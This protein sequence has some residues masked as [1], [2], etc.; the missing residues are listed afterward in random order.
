[1]SLC[2]AIQGDAP[3]EAEGLPG[4]GR[5]SRGYSGASA[6]AEAAGPAGSRGK[7]R[8]VEAGYRHRPAAKAPGGQI[9]NSE[10]SKSGSDSGSELSISDDE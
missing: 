5:Y 8:V 2:N 9:E 7:Q 1:M 6:E 10:G 3:A 4:A